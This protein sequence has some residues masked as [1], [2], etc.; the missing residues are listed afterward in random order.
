MQVTFLGTGTVE[1][2]AL[3]GPS[4]LLVRSAETRVLYDCGSGALQKMVQAGWPLE[5][6]DAVV[7]SH[8]HLDHCADL[9]S[10]L[11]ARTTPP[12]RNAP[13]LHLYLSAPARTWLHRTLRAMGSQ[14][15]PGRARVQLHT[16]H[17]GETVRIG[18]LTLLPL[19]VYHHSSSL[20]VRITSAS[21]SL[22]LP[23]D[24]G[25]TPALLPLC[26]DAD[27]AVLHCALPDE[28][29]VIHHLSPSSTLALLAET[30]PR[31]AAIVHRY[32]ALADDGHTR[33]LLRDA[34]C[35]LVFPRDGETLTLP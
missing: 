19:P 23:S 24:T 6:L 26:T 21:A 10:L 11:F 18:S 28:A 35:P 29:G 14:V 7:L 16:L 22:A 5:R 25:R 1:H 33:Y 3:H 4:A 13:A 34:P 12:L 17:P 32:A 27:L 9:F 20:G 15:A 2:R 31:R 30:R 8:I